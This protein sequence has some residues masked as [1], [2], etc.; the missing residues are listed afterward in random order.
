MPADVTNPDT[1]AARERMAQE[2]F[3]R[4]RDAT[5][6]PAGDRA[7][8]GHAD[9]RVMVAIG[10]VRDALD[11]ITAL[12]A[13]LAP[14]WRAIETCPMWQVAIVT[15]GKNVALAQLAETDIGYPY[16]SIEP[17]DA[18]EWEPTLWTEIPTA[19][20]PSGGGEG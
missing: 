13:A 5:Y 8:A 11:E 19:E 1:P 3:Q 17:E 12:R 14:Q 6:W 9:Q 16:W 4:L 7:F 20:E 2:A 15:D 10:D 18:L